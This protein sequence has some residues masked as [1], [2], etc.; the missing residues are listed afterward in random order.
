[1]RYVIRLTAYFRNPNIGVFAKANDRFAIVPANCQ[2]KFSRQ[3]HETLDVD[4]FHTDISGTSLVGAFV[5]MNNN[6]VMLTQ[7]TYEDEIKKITSDIKIGLLEDRLTALGNLIIVNDNGA[8]VN[9][10]FDRRSIEVMEDTFDCEVVTGEI[11][12]FRTIGSVGMATNKGAIL[13]PMAKEEELKLV[14]EILKVPVDIGT[15]NRGVGFVRTG[16]IAN[17]KGVILGDETTGPEITRIED[18]LGLL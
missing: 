7:H 11:G 14:E 12:G 4:V 10:G 8:V 13:H 2:A 15:V 17:T 3:L 5:S 1:V 18:A 9:K 6:G 16:I